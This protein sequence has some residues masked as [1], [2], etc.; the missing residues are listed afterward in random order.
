M[1]SY[2]HCWEY[3]CQNGD[4]SGAF[5][6]TV[7]LAHSDGGFIQ[8]IWKRVQSFITIHEEQYEKYQRMHL[9]FIR[10]WHQEYK[11]DFGGRVSFSD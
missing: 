8:L 11:V 3:G 5:F 10:Q 7:L 6:A 2:D 9:I 4:S 1:F